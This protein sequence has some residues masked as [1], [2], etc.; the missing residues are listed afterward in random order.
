MLLEMFPPSFW[1]KSTS[2]LRTINLL[3]NVS[4]LKGSRQVSLASFDCYT[5]ILLAAII[6]VENG[7]CDFFGKSSRISSLASSATTSVPSTYF[8]SSLSMDYFS[9]IDPAISNHSQQYTIDWP[10][11]LLGSLVALP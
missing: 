9:S 1:S 7:F 5:I 11:N 8:Q 6:T 4:H 2:S 3:A 10:L